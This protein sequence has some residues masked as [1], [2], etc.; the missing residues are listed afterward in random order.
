MPFE[1]RCV[2]TMSEQNYYAVIE[3]SDGLQIIPSNWLNKDMSMVRWPA[4]TNVQRYE[5]AIRNME[6]PTES[7]TKI[8]VIK[9]VAKD[10]K[11][12][13]LIIIYAIDIFYTFFFDTHFLLL[14]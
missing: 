4:L 3:F 1:Y 5:K 12:K 10:S 9:I 8:P 14:K 6:P 2:R 13:F 11:Y 7:W